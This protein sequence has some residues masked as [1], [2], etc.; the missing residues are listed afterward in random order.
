M[1]LKEEGLLD[2][3]EHWWTEYV[4]IDNIGE[5]WRIKLQRMRQNIRGW[6]NLFWGK[7]RI[8]AGLVEEI[9]EFE[10]KNENYQ[11]GS[12]DLDR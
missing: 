10:K 2:Q 9:G 1:W 12:D 3:L 7:K 11:L 5:N 4:I 6:R 8:K